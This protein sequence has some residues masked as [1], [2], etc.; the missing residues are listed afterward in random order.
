M[1]YVLLKDCDNK[2]LF[3]KIMSSSSLISSSTLNKPFSILA[4][5]FHAF[6]SVLYIM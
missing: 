3:F 6:L 5:S 4:I 2:Y 1:R